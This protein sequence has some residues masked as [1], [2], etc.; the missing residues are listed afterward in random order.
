[1]HIHGTDV[2]HLTVTKIFSVIFCFKTFL[3]SFS[4]EQLLALCLDFF[5]AGTE[6][7]SNTLAFGIIYMLHNPHVLEKIYAE[8][9]VKIGS[10]R[11]PRLSDRSSL[12][13]TE[14][15]LCE[16]QRIANVAPVGIIHRCM[17]TTKLGSFTVPKDTLALVSLYSLHMDA[18]YWHDPHTFR[19]ERFIHCDTGELV[20]HHDHFMPFGAGRFCF[21]QF[22]NYL[23]SKL[24]ICV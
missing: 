7:T 17:E 14:A 19:P 8:L 2:P 10:N 18:E 20:Q 23:K 15:V 9:D 22:N 24:F 21:V 12:P 16:I 4:D 1:M 13:F 5:Q 6:T 11:N 3:N